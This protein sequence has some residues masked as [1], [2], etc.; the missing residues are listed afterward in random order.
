MSQ[1]YQ[2]P[3]EDEVMAS[4]TADWVSKA[5]DHHSQ[6]QAKLARVFSESDRKLRDEKEQLADIWKSP[7]ASSRDEQPK[8]PDLFAAERARADQ[9]RQQLSN[10]WDD[11][12]AARKAEEDQLR[13]MFGGSKSK[14]RR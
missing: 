12:L 1:P 6:K 5:V 9:Q 2:P 10:V 4:G 13:N 14:K 8:G 3:S 7:P 11:D